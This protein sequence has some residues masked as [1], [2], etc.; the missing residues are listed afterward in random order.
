MALDKIRATV[1]RHG[2]KTNA[3]DGDKHDAEFQ[4]EE[5]TLT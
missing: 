5:G 3:V 1:T 2:L 4:D